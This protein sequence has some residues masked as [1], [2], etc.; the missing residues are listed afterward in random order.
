[1]TKSQFQQSAQFYR[2]R[3]KGHLDKKWSDWF[4]DMNICHDGANSILT[5]PLVDQAALHGVLIKIRDLNLTL[6]S[7]KRIERDHSSC[8]DAKISH[9]P[10]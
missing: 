4:D 5:G 7:V 9:E 8:D 3:L 2:I 1:M 10:E 6:L